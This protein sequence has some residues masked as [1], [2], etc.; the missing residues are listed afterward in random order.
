MVGG[1]DAGE[2]EHEAQRR[3]EDGET[4]HWGGSLS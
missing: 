4:A 1:G 3:D 2:R